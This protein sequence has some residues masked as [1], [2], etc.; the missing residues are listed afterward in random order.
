[1]TLAV[2]VLV[3]MPYAQLCAARYTHRHA[4]YNYLWPFV[5][6]QDNSF[7]AIGSAALFADCLTKAQYDDDAKSKIS[8][9]ATSSEG[10][11]LLHASAAL[12]KKRG[13]SKS[14]T[15]HVNGVHRCVMDGNKW[16]DCPGGSEVEDFV[17]TLCAEYHRMS[18]AWPIDVCG[19]APSKL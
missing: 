15:V 6:C 4:S 14:C 19:E 18:G 12:S 7:S 9:C 5:R 3:H 16:Y 1:M 8:T 17:A 11:G 13:V 10:E 2:R